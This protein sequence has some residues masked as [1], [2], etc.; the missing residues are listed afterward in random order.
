MLSGVVGPC[1]HLRPRC[2]HTAYVTL[3]NAQRLRRLNWSKGGLLDAVFVV[4]F[5][6]LRSRCL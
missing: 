1:C 6:K 2:R 4:Q 3:G 5:Q